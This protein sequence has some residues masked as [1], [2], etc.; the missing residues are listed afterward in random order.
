MKLRRTSDDSDD[1]GTVMKTCCC[2]MDVRI[3]TIVLGFCH[4]VSRNSPQKSTCFSDMY[5]LSNFTDLK[6][7]NTLFTRIVRDMKKNIYAI[8]SIDMVM[9]ARN[10]SIFLKRN[11]NIV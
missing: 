11:Q 7:E 1:D 5:L 3:G 9:K 10:V 2:C 6:P 4:L 8:F